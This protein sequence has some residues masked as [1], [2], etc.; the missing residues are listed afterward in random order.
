MQAFRCTGK[1]GIERCAINCLRS[2]VDGESSKE[3]KYLT[4]YFQMQSKEVRAPRAAGRRRGR[5]WP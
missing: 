4:T 1:D 5:L 2:H 3:I